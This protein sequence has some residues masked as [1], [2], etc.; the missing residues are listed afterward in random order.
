MELTSLLLIILIGIFCLTL[1]SV[2]NL[3]AGIPFSIGIGAGVIVVFFC[4]IVSV[5]TTM[6]RDWINRRDRA[7]PD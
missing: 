5:I 1:A 3:F 7:P 4:F 6:L 2:L